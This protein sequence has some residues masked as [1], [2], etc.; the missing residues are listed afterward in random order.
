[1]RDLIKKVLREELQDK[2]VISE[3]GKYKTYCEKH[4]NSISAELPFCSAA[5]DYI[6]NEIDKITINIFSPFMDDGNILY[7]FLKLQNKMQNKI[8]FNFTDEHDEVLHAI[9]SHHGRRE[10]G[11]PVSPS[12]RIA[13]LLHL[14]DSISA[15]M[16]DC[17]IFQYNDDISDSIKKDPKAIFNFVESKKIRE[18][19]QSESKNS[20]GSMLFGATKEDVEI[21]GS[22]KAYPWK[23]NKT[24]IAESFAN[25]Q[26]KELLGK[27]LTT[28]YNI[29]WS[30]S[31]DL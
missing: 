21:N 9:L 7:S 22:K 3:M 2:F 13:W 19:Y 23:S 20:D 27:S 12:T 17:N 6:K 30:K 24:T 29:I 15:R 25:D 10:Y 8:K 14:C 1:M 28:C 11:S 4:F 26:E 31:K 5:E 18:K 16:F